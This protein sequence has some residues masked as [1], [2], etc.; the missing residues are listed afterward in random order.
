MVRVAAGSSG[1]ARL[2]VAIAL[3]YLGAPWIRKCDAASAPRV[4]PTRPST[5]SGSSAFD[6]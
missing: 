1:A 6:R 4:S 5:T 3:Q 2:L